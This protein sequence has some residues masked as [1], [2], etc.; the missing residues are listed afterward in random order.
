MSATG[1]QTTVTTSATR[2]DDAVNTM[3]NAAVL[4]RNRGSVPVFLG[5]AAVTTGTGFQLDAGEA[6]SIDIAGAN[7]P[8]YGVVASG[9]AVCHVLQVGD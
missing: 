7:D 4:I 2:L 6:I 9:S 1:R 5:G 3:A 8:L